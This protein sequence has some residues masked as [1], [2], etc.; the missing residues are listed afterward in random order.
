MLS[1]LRTELFRLKKSTMFWVML[2][3]C[4]GLPLLGLF[5]ILVSVSAVKNAQPN[6][7]FLSL[8][9]EVG[10]LQESLNNY[11]SL[12]SDYTLLSIICSAIFLSKEFSDGTVR[13]VLL[14]NKKREQLYFSY[15]LIALLIGA[16]FVTASFVSL[17]LFYAPIFGF[18]ALTAGEAASACFCSYALGLISVLFCQTCVCM[19]LFAVRKQ[20][21]TIAFPLLI[22]I[23]APVLIEI[24]YG[25]Y[26]MSQSI[27]GNAPSEALASW[28]P[29]MNASL[30]KS[31]SIDGGLVG[32]IIMYYLVFSGV[33]VGAGYG[34]FI[35]A[36]LK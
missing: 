3:V 6:A 33:F 17:M 28:L 22:C 19:F 29:F 30:Y 11:A 26:V 35:K 27:A 21:A 9:R 13:N 31:D 8:L 4:F 25:V 23:F 5:I 10:L 36:D 20:G 1:I 24:F 2:G 12:M 16:A 7:D 14:A 15:Q 34:T 18:G 32:K